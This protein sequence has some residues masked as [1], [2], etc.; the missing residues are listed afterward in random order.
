MLDTANKGGGG[1]LD[2]MLLDDLRA[3]VKLARSYKLQ[4]G[5]AGSLRLE[6]VPT[7]AA[8]SP[9]YLGFRGALCANLQRN[10]QISKFKLIE[11]KELLYQNNKMFSN[12][13]YA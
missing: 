10:S 6:N 9:D 3:F 2:Y 13:V 8:L 11:I 1:L 5:I 7:L 4:S 12:A